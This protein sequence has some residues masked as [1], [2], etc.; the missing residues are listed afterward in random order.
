M[1]SNILYN[2]QQTLT[3]SVYVEDVGNCALEAIDEQGT[4]HY[5]LT[6]TVMG[7]TFTLTF[8]PLVPDIEELPKSYSVTYTKKNYDDEGLAKTIQAWAAPKKGSNIVSIKQI[9]LED[10]IMLYRDASLSFMAQM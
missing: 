8:G 5:F 6:K 3:N 10:A 2:L 7:R 9:P 1:D 4:H